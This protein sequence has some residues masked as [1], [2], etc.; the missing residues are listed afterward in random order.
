VIDVKTKIGYRNFAIILTLLD[1]GMR[2]SEL[3]NLKLEK[4]YLED[5]TFKVQGKGNKERVIPIGKQIQRM[6]WHY[7]ER[8]QPEPMNMY[9][10]N[11]FLTQTDSTLNIRHVQT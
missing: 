9:C 4:L 2:I 3:C 5:S 1:T 7:I 11:V 8:C 10:T 6:L